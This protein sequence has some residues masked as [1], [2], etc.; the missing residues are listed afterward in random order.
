MP[1]AVGPEVVVMLVLET[2]MLPEILFVIAATEVAD[3]LHLSNTI[4]Q[5]PLEP[6]PT[7]TAVP[8]DVEETLPPR[9]AVKL[10]N[11]IFIFPITVSATKQLLVVLNVEFE[12]D[13]FPIPLW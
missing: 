7:N 8:P 4:S 11:D 12:T 3:I 1:Y 13:V 6:P 5:G 9:P 2:V 10:Q